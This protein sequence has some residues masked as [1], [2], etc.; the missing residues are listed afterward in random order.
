MQPRTSHR[1]HWRTTLLGIAAGIGFLWVEHEAHLSRTQ[2]KLLLCLMVLVFYVIAGLWSHASVLAESRVKPRR[3]PVIV[4]T[5]ASPYDL[6]D[7]P[8]LLPQPAR[9]DVLDDPVR[10]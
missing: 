8:G 5:P 3:A 10:R 9:I 2:H 1:S 7:L 6:P 4:V